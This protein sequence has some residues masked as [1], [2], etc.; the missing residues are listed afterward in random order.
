V[1]RF[2]LVVL[3]TVA[4]QR[5]ERA[6]ADRVNAVSQIAWDQYREAIVTLCNPIRLEKLRRCAKRIQD[7]HDETWQGFNRLV[8]DESPE[9]FHQLMT[10]AQT[11]GELWYDEYQT[12][13]QQIGEFSDL[14]LQWFAAV[15]DW[16][17]LDQYIR[18]QRLERGLPWFY[19]ELDSL[20]QERMASDRH[21]MVP[22]F[23]IHGVWGLYDDARTMFGAIERV[24]TLSKFGDSLPAFDRL[25]EDTGLFPTARVDGYLYTIEEVA[26]RMGMLYAFVQ[27]IDRS[28]WPIHAPENPPLA[29]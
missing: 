24:K 2:A 3:A 8:G 10:F 18:L 28:G 22:F 29:S 15:R 13:T 19:R 11:Q 23:E 21:P 12:T 6:A 9:A 14:R 16:N 25:M 27:Q 5:D 4:S 7:I 1:C 20:L 26:H 17:T